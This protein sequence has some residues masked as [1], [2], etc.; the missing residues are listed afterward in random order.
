MLLQFGHLNDVTALMALISG[1][2]PVTALMALISGFFPADSV[3]KLQRALK[4]SETL[5]LVATSWTY[6]YR[7][8][9]LII[10]RNLSKST[11]PILRI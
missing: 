10:T 9:N 7:E 2:F 6:D 4:P 11:Q 3:Q 8:S 1:F 5:H